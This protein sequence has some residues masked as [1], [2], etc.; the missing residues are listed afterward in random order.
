MYLKTKSNSA[1]TLIELLVA[2]LLFSAIT[3][4]TVLM[5]ATGLKIWSS[6]KDRLD[7]RQDGSLAIEKM[8]RY[9]ELA[10][11]ITNAATNSITFSADVNNDSIL[12][13]VTI[14]FDD[15]N[16]KLDGT[17]NGATTT[18]T[19]YVQDFNFSYCEAD[20]EIPFKPPQPNTQAKRDS[21]RVIVLLLTM[22][23]GNDTATLSTSVFCRNQ[24]II[25]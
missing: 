17:I 7:I 12:D 14:A 6:N 8:V 21:I 18:L 11:N 25:P 16:K 20:T 1:L 24:G 10:S 9:L 23:K 22:N 4:A 15:A 3:G 2:I 13:T 5:F 19:P